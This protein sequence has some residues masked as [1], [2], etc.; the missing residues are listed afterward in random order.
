ME[1]DQLLIGWATDP[2]RPT[3]SYSTDQHR[4]WN[5]FNSRCH[6]CLLSKEGLI[7][8]KN[9]FC[10]SL[11]IPIAITKFSGLNV[12][13]CIYIVC[14]RCR[15]IKCSFNHISRSEGYDRLLRL[16]FEYFTYWI[17]ATYLSIS[18]SIYM[19]QVNL[20]SG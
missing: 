20:L 11:Y 1:N 15:T 6:A 9:L 17:E 14:G 4:P 16:T 3:H 7:W 5:F 10:F 12:F 13:I 2:A 18:L 19:S 8:F